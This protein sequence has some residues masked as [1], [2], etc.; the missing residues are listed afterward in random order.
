[1]TA[2]RLVI[3]WPAVCSVDLWV[4]AE[5]MEKQGKQLPTSRRLLDRWGQRFGPGFLD[6]L[7]LDGLYVAQ[8]FINP[9]LEMKIDVAL[10]TEEEGLLILQQANALFD[11]RQIF[12]GMEYQGGFDLER[13]CQYQV[14]A[15]G[16]FHHTGVEAPFWVARV[17]ESYP[18]QPPGKQHRLFYMC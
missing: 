7:L 8:D 9:C 4:D 11:H 6:L 12:T 10:K 14:W 1:M 13:G 17:Q 18:T 3:F 16:G 2:V 15:S 5:P